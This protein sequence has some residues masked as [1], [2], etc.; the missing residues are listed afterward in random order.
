M[1]T[2]PALWELTVLLALASLHGFVWGYMAGNVDESSALVRTPEISD[3][4]GRVQKRSFCTHT[5]SRGF[6]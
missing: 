4:W 3:S 2:D 1:V 6:W 5:R